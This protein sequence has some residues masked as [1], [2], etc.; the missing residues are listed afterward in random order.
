MDN[1]TD[2]KIEKKNL[3]KDVQQHQIRLGNNKGFNYIEEENVRNY[4][5]MR[6]TPRKIGE[7]LY[8]FIE[9]IIPI[10]AILAIIDNFL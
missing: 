10:E 1:L 2:S 8:D 7:M 3:K 5:K 4:I 6:S 9:E